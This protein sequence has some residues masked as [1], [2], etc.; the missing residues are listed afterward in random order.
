MCVQKVEH[1]Y[2][3]SVTL[4]R[5]QLACHLFCPVDM[6]HSSHAVLYHDN[7]LHIGCYETTVEMRVVW[8]GASICADLR[9]TTRTRIRVGHFAQRHRYCPAK[10]PVGLV[11]NYS[12]DKTAWD[13]RSGPIIFINVTEQI[14]TTQRF[15]V[16]AVDNVGL[17]LVDAEDF[18]VFPP[19][20]F[21]G[22]FLCATQG[23]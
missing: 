16:Q 20:T 18:G 2:M 22:I 17:S 6:S 21:S 13:P 1:N 15:S 9:L 4:S 23:I 10:C 19:C 3:E 12:W 14:S 7:Q 11:M 8:C 5:F